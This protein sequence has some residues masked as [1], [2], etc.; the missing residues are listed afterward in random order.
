VDGLYYYMRVAR[1]AFMAE[2]AD[3]EPVRVTGALGVAI[4]VCLAAVVGLGFWPGPLY[5]AS[6]GAGAAVVE[7]H[8]R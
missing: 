4:A 3:A 5:R 1:A 2:P 7:R 8:D 6:A